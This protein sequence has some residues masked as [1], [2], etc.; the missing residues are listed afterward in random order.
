MSAPLA[1]S[2][3][4]GPATSGRA[5]LGCGS[6]GGIGSTL[7]TLG[8]GLDEAAAFAVM[9]EAARLGISIFDTA[10]GYAG[11]ESERI[12][13][14]WLH[15]R[16]HP[17]TVTTK[18]GVAGGTVHGRDLSPQRVVS[19]AYASRERLGVPRIEMYMIHAADPSTP[20]EASLAAFDGLHRDG[21]IAALGMCNVTVDIL[22][23]WT[24]AAERMGA[25]RIAWVQNEY[26]LLCRRDERDILPYCRANGLAYTAYSPLDGGILAGRYQRGEPPP[27]N[28]RIA[29]LPEQYGPR[30][31]DHVHDGLEKLGRYATVRGVSMAGL[32]MAWVMSNADVAAPLVAPRTPAQFDAVVEGVSFTLSEAERAEIAA[33]FDY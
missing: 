14:L 1:A 15:A 9:D 25:I 33:F 18:V 23:D 22:D 13:G 29:V 28:S 17:V 30:L 4:I 10:D 26:S 27:P 2:R 16:G 6:I 32:A 3:V 12:I 24:A 19:H 21:V 11:G 5:I 8:T 31:D 20:I 7:S